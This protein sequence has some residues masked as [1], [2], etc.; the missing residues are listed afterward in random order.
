MAAQITWCNPPSI[1]RCSHTIELAATT[2]GM[3]LQAAAAAGAEGPAGAAGAAG[4]EGPAGA[5][6]YR[7]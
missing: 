3:Q 5:A 7:G 4:A 1:H 2:G 6:G